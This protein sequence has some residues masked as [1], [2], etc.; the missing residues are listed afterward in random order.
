MPIP[1][2]FPAM[3]DLRLSSLSG[4]SPLFIPADHSL[5]ESYVMGNC[6]NPHARC[7]EGQRIICTLPEIHF[8]RLRRASPEQR[9]F[10]G[11]VMR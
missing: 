4:T 6:A 10:H 3:T 1:I 7:M 2:S 9:A 11:A 8:V 5:H